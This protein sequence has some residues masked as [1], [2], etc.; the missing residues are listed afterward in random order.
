[1]H[2]NKK[3]NKKMIEI[4]IYKKAKLKSHIRLKSTNFFT[5]AKTQIEFL[6]SFHAVVC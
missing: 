2:L 3:F 5:Q 4:G 1:M 6:K